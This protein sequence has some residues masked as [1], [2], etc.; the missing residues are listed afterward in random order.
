MTIN[1]FLKK[2]ASDIKGT[3][4]NFTSEDFYYILKYAGVKKNATKAQDIEK[5]YQDFVDNLNN[6]LVKYE[7]RKVKNLADGTNYIGFYVDKKADYL[8]AVKLYFPVKYDYLISAL[9][10][11]F[12]Y[13]IRNNIKA[14]VKFHNKATNEGIVIRFYDKSDVMP[15]INYCNNNFVLK[16]LIVSCNPFIATIFGLGIVRDDNTVNSYN[17]MLSNMLEE[18][19]RFHREINT[20]DRVCD[21]DFLDYLIRRL[22]IEKDEK[23]KF[24]IKAIISNIKAILNKE[25]PL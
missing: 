4:K 6:S 19:F 1:D 3:D 21:I 16:D 15:F 11:T 25:N 14:T 5:F 9:K 8:E 17:G 20:I 18:Y 13:L 12:L 2:I 24:N 22:D 7:K 23:N 10:T